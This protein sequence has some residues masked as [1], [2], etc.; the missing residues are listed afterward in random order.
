MSKRDLGQA[1]LSG[2]AKRSLLACLLA[3]SFM[4][5]PASFAQDNTKVIYDTAYFQKY[6]TVTLEDMIKNIPGGTAMLSDIR[7]AAREDQGSR[8]FGNTG[9]QILINGKRL[10]GKA[11]D[12]AANLTRISADRVER[13]ELIRGT[14]EGLDI[15]SDGIL[16]NVILKEGADSMSSTLVEARVDY[17]DGGKFRPS[18]QVAYSGK[19]GNVNYGI[20]YQYKIWQRI[21]RVD[22][23]VLNADQSPRQFR[24]YEAN[25][26]K[27]E[28]IV[29]GNVG[30][31]F[32]NG[33]RLRLNG[34]YNDNQY[35]ETVV[36]EQ[37][38][39]N[40]QTLVAIENTI[41]DNVKDNW[42]IGGDFETTLGGLGTFKSL[43]IVTSADNN[44]NL[45]QDNVA[46]G[47]TTINYDNTAL[48]Q[49]D[50]K[51]L[52]AS[53][54]S[55]PFEGH[56]LEYGGEGAFNK[57]DK[58]Q[59]FVNAPDDRAVVKEDRYEMFIT[60]SFN[61]LDMVSVQ[62]TLTQ[63]FSKIFQDREGTTNTRK[64]DYLKP[65]F[66]LRYDLTASDQIRLSTERTVSQLNLNFFV[67]SRNIADDSIDFG[68]PN[69][70]PEKV[71]LHSVAYE[72][73]LDQDAGSIEAKLSYQDISDHIDR[74]QIGDPNGASSGV[75]NIGDAYR[76][77]FDLRGN[78]RLGFIGLPNADITASY[79]YMKHE[80]TDPFT[81]EKR[82]TTGW[83]PHYWNI[84]FQHTLPE[85]NF[86]YGF[87]LHR[88]TP[89]YR[90]DIFLFEKR[91]F[92]R[93]F[94]VFAEYTFMGDIKARL[95]LGHLLKDIKTFD[96]TYYDGNIADGVIDRYEN[97]VERMSPDLYFS[98]Q[99]TF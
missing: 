91:G 76:L 63:E 21:L 14:A 64:F 92:R 19:T 28:H 23:D 5:A 29:T 42:E 79:R 87:N 49:E 65:R 81:L 77:Q 62:S 18:G 33:A 11:N 61:P 90:Q 88:R 8:G 71:W 32:D 56:T 44:N 43:F 80:T 15:Q 95:H 59:V 6:S 82:Q 30:F 72:K 50:E 17:S 9:A 27:Q 47:I 75:G 13:I 45:T 83:N 24:P 73:R 22:E 70:E 58:S 69:L 78:F 85:W 96:K 99:T 16:F 57:L 25:K 67:A 7:R 48:F 31:D 12:I 1:I 66:E 38:D 93:H 41:F 55:T 46:N 35:D 10:S 86:K 37:F 4:M 54:T 20:G 36:E 89:S 52:R 40:P 97:R 51:I 53:M 84:D 68:N 2:T 74:I 3:T 34:L 39:L 26:Y 98:L 60:H 94:T